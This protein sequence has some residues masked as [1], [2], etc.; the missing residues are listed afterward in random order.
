MILTTYTQCTIQRII[1]CISFSSCKPSVSRFSHSGIHCTKSC[2][3]INNT[4]FPFY[5]NWLNLFLLCIFKYLYIFKTC[6]SHQPLTIILYVGSVKRNKYYILGY[7]KCMSFCLHK[8]IVWY[9]F[10]LYVK[11]KNYVRIINFSGYCNHIIDLNVTLIYILK[12]WMNH[13]SLQIRLF[14]TFTNFANQI[15][16]F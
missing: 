13:V 1:H 2:D 10:V 15:Y 16:F 8:V 12:T 14:L 4:V 7:W 3:N 5:Q 11:N 6:N 9:W